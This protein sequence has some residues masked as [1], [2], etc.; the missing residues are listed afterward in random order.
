[1]S[2]KTKK[3]LAV[4]G[5]AAIWLF[6]IFAVVITALVLSSTNS[7]AG[8]ASFSG[9]SFINVKTDSMYP[10]IK[11]GDLIVVK[12][13]T[14]TKKSECKEG[15]IITYYT[16]LDGDG[17]EELNTHRVAE[18]YEE[19]GYVYYRTRGDNGDGDKNPDTLSPI[20]QNPVAASKVIGTWTGTRIALLGS[21]LGVL[22]TSTGFMLAI[23]LPLILF[24]LYE[25]IKFIRALTGAKGKKAISETEKEE[26]K[27]LAIE[28]YLRQKQGEDSIPAEAE[29]EAEDEELAAETAETAED[30]SE[31]AE[32]PSGEEDPGGE[33]K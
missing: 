30:L 20:D 10:T 8:V 15:D 2:A 1:M 32:P 4:I 27:R 5:N 9:K 25:L 24:F 6:V 19:N 33:T 14:D 18:V 29:A 22:Q 31:P 23:V 3:V 11:S 28:E 7:E 21:V 17:A 13:L 12:L 16:D 26:I